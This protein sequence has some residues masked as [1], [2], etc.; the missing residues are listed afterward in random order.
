MSAQSFEAVEFDPFAQD[1]LERVL[2]TSSAQREVWLADKLSREASLAFNESAQLRLRGP[3][4]A[5]E[6]QQALDALV[7]R[8]ASLRATIGPDGTELLVGAPAGLALNHVD[9]SDLDADTRQASLAQAAALAVEEPFDLERGPMLR[10][11]LYRLGATDHVLLLTA[12]HVVCD[13]WSW[14]VMT[15]DLG[16]L[17]AEALGEAPGPDAAADYGDYVAWE[18]TE[19]ASPQMAEHERFWLSRFSGGSLPV[20]DLP[21]DRQRAAVRS[22]NSRRID[23]TI[24]VALVSEVRRLGARAGA[25]V[26][27]TLFSAF[28][29]LLNRLTGQDDVVVGVPSAGQSASG[30]TSLVGHCVNLLPVRSA[31]DPKQPFDALVATCGGTLLDAF[32]HQTLTYG[33][34]LAKL[35]VQRD[36]SRLPLVSVMFNVD[37][38]VHSR[39]QAFPELD[40]EFSVNPRRYEN[41]EL[42]INASQIDGALRLECQYNTDLFDAATIERWLGAYEALL[43]RAVAAPATP[44]GELDL[45]DTGARAALL[46]QQPAATPFAREALMHTAFV[47][48]ASRTP[49]RIAVT[50]GDRHLSYLELDQRSNRLAQALRQR[51]VRRGDRVGLC[52]TRGVDMVTALLAVLKAGAAYV[53]LDPGFPPAR[54]AYYAEDAALALLVTES[55]IEVAPRQWRA[56]SAS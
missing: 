39:S 21:T 2:P 56:D 36:P 7:A 20:L 54:L 44:V 51:G 53:P 5:A 28:A 48:Q 13:G 6:L 12:H 10:A 19:A 8:H 3:L 15:E 35:P 49:Q 47:Q 40:V 37:Q 42:F 55:T 11:T 4:R 32:E 38:A 30:L 22:F 9:L 1:V 16:A 34:L 24:D 46:A 50:S 52:L 23:R 41:F 14:G 27:A 26:F 25:S 45:L 31:V 43:R 33:S 18:A 17:Y 29:A